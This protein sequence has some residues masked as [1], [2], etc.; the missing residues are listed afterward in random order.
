VR[1]AL[2]IVGAAVV[3]LAAVACALLAADFLLLER[4]MRS[5]DTRFASGSLASDLWQPH[6][7]L[8]FGAAKELLA[9]DDDVAYRDAVRA[10]VLGRPREQAFRTPDL[11]GERGQAQDL[12]QSIV[13]SHQDAKRRAEAANLIGVLG[14]ANA[15]IDPDQAY[16]YLSE[17][18]GRFRQAIALDPGSDDAKYNLELALTRIKKTPKPSGQKQPQDNRG[19][20]G[21][22]AGTGD[23]GSGY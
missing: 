21:G 22:G 5:S 6:Q 7:I 14:F 16:S 12:L 18:I 10:F 19:G 3:V 4:G 17:A 20:T 1:K 2:R 8:P 23:A 9:V 11:L 15:A 13:E